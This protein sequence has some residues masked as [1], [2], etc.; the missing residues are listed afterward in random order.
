LSGPQLARFE[1]YA[2]RVRY[3]K[4]QGKDR[5]G[6]SA[7]IQ[8]MQAR[9]TR[10]LLPSLLYLSTT[11]SY[12]ELQYVVGTGSSLL[13]LCCRPPVTE[14]P[15]VDIWTLVHISANSR[16]RSLRYLK[17]DLILPD[18]CLKAI[19]QLSNLK[20]LVLYNS[21]ISPTTLNSN[22]FQTISKFKYLTK[23]VL[24]ISLDI[25]IENL[26]LSNSPV[27]PALNSLWICSQ[28]SQLSKII[29]LLDIGKFEHLDELRL[30]FP[31]LPDDG[32]KG[33]AAMPWVQFFKTLCLKTSPRLKSLN[34]ESPTFNL[35]KPIPEWPTLSLSDIPDLSLPKL[36]RLRIAFPI[37]PTITNADIHKII[38]SFPSLISLI[39]IA[40]LP[41]QTNLSSLIDIAR[42]LPNLRVLCLG[43]DAHLLPP[44]TQVPLLSHNL[45]SLCLAISRLEDPGQLA[46]YLD[47]IFPKLQTYVINGSGND[48]EDPV[49]NQALE[50][51][52]RSLNRFISARADQMHRIGM[53]P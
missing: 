50:E 24:S 29:H 5:V 18:S 13:A 6:T 15:P 49:K 36:T 10:A 8:L 14:T 3:Y 38:T 11:V 17:L 39:L 44:P 1:K 42:G 43:L 37:F 7:Y 51:T 25:S 45:C 32:W 9:Q 20:N 33:I 19:T 48:L 2:N 4:C 22:F 16:K 52:R 53:M 40:Q 26:T 12:P 47:K 23:L 30:K 31:Q 35:Q 34:I 28:P 41:G 46:Y 27:F 21:I